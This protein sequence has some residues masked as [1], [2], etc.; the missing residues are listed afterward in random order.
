MEEKEEKD[1]LLSSQ[2]GTFEVVQ[3]PESPRA[4]Y[5]KPAIKAAVN[6]K[7]QK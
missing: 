5:L 6:F 4:K 2:A 3:T 1:L 7:D